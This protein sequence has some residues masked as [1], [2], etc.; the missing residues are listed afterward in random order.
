MISS[1]SAI[2]HTCI[3]CDSCR[4][5]KSKCERGAGD[6]S[7]CKS[8]ALAGSSKSD[9]LS[10][11]RLIN[12]LKACTFL[13][14]S[15]KRGPPKGYIHAIEQRWHQVESLLGVILQCSDPRVQSIVADLRQD[16]LARE[17]LN[18]V[19]HGPYGPSGRRFQPQGATKEDFFASVLRS[20]G[21]TSSG[22]D[23]S[24]SRRQSRVSREKVSLTQGVYSRN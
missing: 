18:R 22:R 11:F 12:A 1:K 9:H 14:P 10:P 16:E 19:D 20:N 17:I 21:S 3:A 4:K 7:P 13:G 6:G 2:N 24:R 23:N 15:Y 8:C 5:T